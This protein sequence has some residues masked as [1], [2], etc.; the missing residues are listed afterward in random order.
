MQCGRLPVHVN[1]NLQNP[2]QPNQGIPRNMTGM[3]A[4]MKLANYSTHFVG[5]W[6]AGMATPF[7]TPQVRLPMLIVCVQ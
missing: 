3:A 7:H 6:D 1:Q 4:K 5:K 2:D